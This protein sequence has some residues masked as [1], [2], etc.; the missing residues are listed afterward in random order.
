[1]E[2]RLG[3]NSDSF[4]RRS[5]QRFV[6]QPG[7]SEKCF[8]PEFN[9]KSQLNWSID[10]QF[11]EPPSAARFC[12]APAR[13]GNPT[14]NKECMNI[15]KLSQSL[16]FAAATLG[17]LIGTA[18]Y[19]DTLTQRNGTQ[20]TTAMGAGWNL[21]NQLEATINGTPNETAW[22][23]PAVSQSLINAVKA[24]GFKT[25]RIPVS[26]LNYIGPGPSYTIN[27]TWLAR[28]K[29]VVDYAYSQGLYV[30]TNI[31]G[32][33]Y[34]SVAG[35]WLLCNASDQTTIKA[36][37][38][39]V[40]QQIA[41]TFVNYN[42]RLIFES[43][44]E[45]FDGVTY[46]APVNQTYYG[47]INAYNQIFVNTVRQTGGNNASR[48]LLVPG[49]NTSIDLT[50]SSNG[51]VIPTDTFRSSAVP[52]AEKRLMISVHYYSP[53]DF[54]GDT[55]SAISQWGVT[56]TDSAKK[57]TWGQEDYL[58]AQF[59]QMYNTYVTQGYPFV[60]GE[61][62]SI[63]KTARD[64]ANATYREAFANAVCVTAKKYGGVPVVWDEGA[65]GADSFGLFNRST[66]AIVQS[67]IVNAI[68]RGSSI[69]NGATLR[70]RNITSSIYIDGMGRTTN[71]SNCGQ[72]AGGTSNNQKWTLEL[73]GN[74]YRLRN[75]ST[76][77]YLDGM[78]RTTA[79]SICGQYA[80]GTSSNQKWILQPYGRY[81]RLKNVGSGLYADGG[82]TTTNG[83]DLKQW[84]DVSNTNLQWLISP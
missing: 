22:G 60:V 75:V 69:V 72:W 21:G 35:S 16:L 41:T 24:A 73:T 20:L 55:G 47:N 42:E 61:Y 78:G 58:E 12:F 65:T 11:S 29:Q 9:T 51:F 64:S 52:S 77:L 14:R 17:S 15:K 2:V 46:G 49:W 31:H 36:K 27:A 63:N 38:K 62:G 74:Y 57:S 37:Y 25:I 43:M 30:V 76:G 48:W 19:A 40:W 70:F 33:G 80:G 23:N 84:T 39:A 67:G 1:M 5:A 71:G 53:W 79:G 82:G 4:A 59:Q 34:T 83:A 10:V 81:L 68:I 13:P 7:R 54:C 8:F 45:E 50:T 66:N 28:V 18:A 44:N 32:D 26:Y 3:A 56:S 6:V